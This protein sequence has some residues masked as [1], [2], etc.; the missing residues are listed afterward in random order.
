MKTLQEKYRSGSLSSDDLRELKEMVQDVPDKT[1]EEEMKDHW[2]RGSIDD[3]EVPRQKLNLIFSRIQREIHRRKR[4]EGILKW[5]SLA[6]ALLIPLCLVFTAKT[7]TT[8]NRQAGQ[9]LLI[10]TGKG[11]TSNVT[12]P[13]G[14]SVKLN[15]LSELRYSPGDFGNK[16]RSL[17][18]NGE[19]YFNVS[20]KDNCPFSI[21]ADKLEV[22]VL[23]TRF[24]LSARSSDAFDK[25]FLEEG[26]VRLVSIING[27]SVVLNPNEEAFLNKG[28][29]KM[30][31]KKPANIESET[32]WINKEI[33][34][35][36]M[37]LGTL[38]DKL[39]QIYDVEFSCGSRIDK[40]ELFTGTLPTDNLLDCSKILEYA[41]GVKIVI[42]DKKVILSK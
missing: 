33:V 18:F 37:S 25:L 36:G 32:S 2:L 42:V 14:T 11:E 8:A 5:T 24:N 9:I 38:L 6:A 17:S 20:K 22:T 10:S 28:T 3:A 31:V 26:L 15:E 21:T 12:L 19:A 30:E 13:D 23:G 1:L 35:E 40:N 29:G 39:S 34:I 41:Y 7:Y 16:K 4:V 27:E